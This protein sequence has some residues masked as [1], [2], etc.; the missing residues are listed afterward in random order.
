MKKNLILVDA[1]V[2]IHESFVIEKVLDSALANFKKA[3]HRIGENSK[4]D[5]VLFLTETAEMNK[6]SQLQSLCK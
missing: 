3:S 4:F 5:G 6:Y 1:H 2:H